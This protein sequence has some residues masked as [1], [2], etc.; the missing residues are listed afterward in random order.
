MS[1]TEDLADK[2]KEFYHSS[3]RVIHS[4]HNLKPY[5]QLKT[6]FEILLKFDEKN[7]CLCG[8]DAFNIFNSLFNNE[9]VNFY[10]IKNYKE[11]WIYFHDLINLKQNKKVYS[12]RRR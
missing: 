12:S 10:Q 7:S 6:F 4:M 9:I 3:W 1:E 11:F 5:E 2:R 8:N